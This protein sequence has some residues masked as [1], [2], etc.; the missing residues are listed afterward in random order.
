MIRAAEMVG[1]VIER[2]QSLR[3]VRYTADERGESTFLYRDES[4]A[5]LDVS[6]QS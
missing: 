6:S 3:E 4:R 1:F 5:D 2:R